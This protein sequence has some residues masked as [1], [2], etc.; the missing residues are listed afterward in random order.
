MRL[1]AINTYVT[2]FQRVKNPGAA[3]LDGSGSRSHV[4]LKSRFGGLGGVVMNPPSNA[5]DVSSISGQGTKI[6]HATERLSPWATAREPA[7]CD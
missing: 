7:G 6:P 4:R 2:P 3:Y 5:G 1:K